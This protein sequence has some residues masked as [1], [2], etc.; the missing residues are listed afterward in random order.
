MEMVIEWSEERHAF[1]AKFPEQFIATGTTEEEAKQNGY[2]ELSRRL[3]AQLEATD[4]Q[5][6]ELKAS[7]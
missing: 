2:A 4:R 3:A 5:L 7:L 1:V 6:A